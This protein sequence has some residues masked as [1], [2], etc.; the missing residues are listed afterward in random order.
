VSHDFHEVQRG[1]VTKLPEAMKLRTRLNLVVAGLSAAFVSVVLIAEV[2]R[3]RVS[4]DEEITAANRVAAQVLGHVASQGA[5]GTTASL[6]GF[7]DELGRVRANELTLLSPSGATLY[8]SPPSEWK[9]GRDAP[10]W[11]ARL[12]MPDAR[13][14]TYALA[15]GGSL[16]VEAEA[17]RAVLDAWDAF[18]RLLLTGIAML[19]VATGAAFWL[20]GRALAPFP[21][22]ADGLSR[23]QSGD[24]K[25]RLP[26]LRGAEAGVMGDAFNAMAA[27]VEDKVKAERQAREAETRLEERREFGR[28]IEQR[29][30][31]ERRLIAH[32]LHDEFSQS[33]TG[34]RSLALAIANRSSDAD[35]RNR[36]AA[37]RISDTAR[38]IADEAARLYDAMH[39]LI[40]R[41][42]PVDFDELNLGE[43]L[44]NFA[45][46]WRKRAPEV[47]I[48]FEY[49]VHCDLGQRVMLT[50]YRVVQEGLV[51]AL[52]HGAPTAVDIAVATE[53]DRIVVSVI[54]DG[55]GLPENWSRPGHFGL[56]GLRSRVE[57]LLGRLTVENRAPQGVALRAEIPLETGDRA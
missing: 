8:R 25:F 10:A 7:L 21:V 38:L 32:E 35:A 9:P 24:L 42:E 11:F 23:I 17:S 49:G 6:T 45:A 5:P 15:D 30:D 33:V 44:E 26:P 27:A 41:L 46:T 1:L 43:A 18:L 48:R 29:I 2:R 31:E 20:V 53:Q 12:L 28:L 19:I 22:I 13:R 4:I 39:G 36:D 37:D 56:R 55:S 16:I 40:P 51:N 47:A 3:A 57:N 14:E 52:R 34:I 54:D 50:I